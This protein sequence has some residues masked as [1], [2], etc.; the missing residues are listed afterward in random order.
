MTPRWSVI[1]LWLVCPFAFWLTSYRPFA[2]SSGL[3]KTMPVEVGGYILRA[4]HEITRRMA[5]LLG[6]DDAIWRTY[7]APD[8]EPVYVVLVCHRE[9]W[10]SVHPP[11]ICLRGSNMIL[12]DD[13]LLERAG[14]LEL[15]NEASNRSYL[16][17]YQYGADGL[18][19]GSYSSFFLHHAPRALF[20]A[21][22]TGYLLR[23][24]TDFD[25]GER[26]A[27]YARC[28][29]MLDALVPFLSEVAQ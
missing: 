5:Q 16:S 28:E 11:D 27:A 15:F 1:V 2:G 10:K 3:A 6:T 20:R 24:E 4:D 7:G 9:N 22:T 19:T 18:A 13:R 14:A 8:G 29:R 17:I 25:D 12:T 26:A 23:I 21:S